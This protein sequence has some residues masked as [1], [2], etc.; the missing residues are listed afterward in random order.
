M[1]FHPECDLCHA[2]AQQI[3]QNAFNTKDVQW[4][5]VSYAARDSINKFAETYHLADISAMSLL[6][7]SQFSLYDRLK[8]TG[9]PT[10][11]IYN[12]QHQ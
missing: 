7:D 6:M 8:V 1:Y 9:I 11:F 12:R 10:S 5:L 4:I 2:K 3:Q